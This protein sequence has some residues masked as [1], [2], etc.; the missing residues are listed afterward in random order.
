L[1]LG[2]IRTDGRENF[3]TAIEIAAAKDD[4]TPIVPEVCIYFE[5]QLLRANRTV[6]YNAD[7]F[8]AF[9]S[10]NY[11]S[12][13]EVGIHINYNRNYILKPNFKKLKVHKKL[14]TNVGIMKLFP[15]IPLHFMKSLLQTEGLQAVVLETF[16]SGNAPNHPEFIDLLSQAID[17]GMIIVNVTQCMTGTVEQGKYE[18]SSQLKKIGVISGKDMST[19]ATITKLMYLLGRYPDLASIKE[20]IQQSIRGE[21]IN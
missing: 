18:T 1:P 20:L 7:F 13:A 16:G 2:V 3:L 15:G 19:E 14:N 10:G 6:K 9:V 12:L 5:N 17:R 11:P 21:I 8:H 4:E